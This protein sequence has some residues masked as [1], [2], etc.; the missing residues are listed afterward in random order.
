MG[1]DL[2]VQL[3]YQSS[4]A[5]KLSQQAVQAA[6]SQK[7]VEAQ[8]LMKQAAEAG[9]NCMAMLKQTALENSELPD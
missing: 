7:F 3:K 4:Q 6:R 2:R 5:V 8:A 1:S 9:R